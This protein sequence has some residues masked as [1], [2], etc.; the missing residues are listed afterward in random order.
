VDIFDAGP[1]LRAKAKSIRTVRAARTARLRSATAHP[2]PEK[3]FLLAHAALDFRAALAPLIEHE[4]G[5]VSLSAT[6]AAALALDPGDTITIS[7]PR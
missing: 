4:D 2:S 3:Q 1:Q 6:T 5:T 7:P